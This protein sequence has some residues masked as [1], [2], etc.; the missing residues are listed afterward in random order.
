MS[1]HI[2][3]T[4]DIS[5]KN[6]ETLAIKTLNKVQI[7]LKMLQKAKSKEHFKEPNIE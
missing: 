3:I 7:F 4:I 5:R 2:E 1:K 6:N